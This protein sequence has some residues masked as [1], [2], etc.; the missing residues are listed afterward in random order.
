MAAYPHKECSLSFCDRAN[1]AKNL[2]NVHYSYLWK[3]V[4]IDEM[5][6]IKKKIKKHCYI[7]KCN[8]FSHS[9]GLCSK[10]YQRYKKYGSPEEIDPRKKSMKI[11]KDGYV[12]I[13][14]SHPENSSGKRGYAHRIIMSNYLGR[15]LYD[16]ENVHHKNGNRQDNRIENLELWSKSQPAGQRIEEKMEWVYQ[17]LDLY[18]KDFPRGDFYV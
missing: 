11:D 16:E 12:I 4:S 1:H 2:C 9:Y 10:H 7:E 14:A 8:N 15:E 6:P 3:G 17:M 18:E 5:K 13:N